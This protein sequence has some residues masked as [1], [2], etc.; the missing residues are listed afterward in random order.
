MPARSKSCARAIV[1][2]TP[3]QPPRFT[4]EMRLIGIADDCGEAGHVSRRRAADQF[5]KSLKAE[6]AIERLRSEPKT[7]RCTGV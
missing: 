7:R 6:D 2:V 1:G 3:G 5:E 4:T